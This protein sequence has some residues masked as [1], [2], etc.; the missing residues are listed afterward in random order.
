M[1]NFFGGKSTSFL[2]WICPLLK[3]QYVPENEY[4]YFEGDQVEGIFFIKQGEISFVLPKHSNTRYIELKDGHHFGINDIVGSIL[5]NDELEFDNWFSNIEKIKRNFNVMST[6]D[7]N[8]MM[9][10]VLD[11]NRMSLE[12]LEYYDKLMEDAYDKL[13]KALIL[14]L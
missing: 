10:T 6:A 4:I 8:I 12:F 7:T 9:L 5:Q 1:I 11:L 2:A 13:Q 3:A 14:K